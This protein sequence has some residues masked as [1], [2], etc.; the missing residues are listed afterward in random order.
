MRP[1]V[2]PAISTAWTAGC[3]LTAIA[4]PVP[5]AVVGMAM[6]GAVAGAVAT[7]APTFWHSTLEKI[8][9]EIKTYHERVV[10]G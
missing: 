1:D 8:A 4:A 10:E 3:T 6:V 9:E 7:G 5:P 2:F